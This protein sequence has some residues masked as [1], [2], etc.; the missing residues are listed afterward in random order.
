VAAVGAGTADAARAHGWPVALVPARHD[1]A[2]LAQAMA[3]AAPLRGARVLFPRAAAAR[4]TLPAALRAAGAEVTEVT[5]Y[6]T[7]AD[8]PGAAALR[9]HLL[10]RDVAVVT[11]A[12]GSAAHALVERV[13]VA[14]AARTRLVSIG[15]VTAAAVRSL[16]LDVVA[17]ASEASVAGIVA[18][19]VAASRDLVAARTADAGAPRPLTSPAPSL[20]DRA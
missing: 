4:D 11:L 9:A 19:V 16:G 2:A 12:S 8:A 10:R 6:R 20:E 14:L 13:G 3:A 7:V 15:A 5:L 1:A 17:E 18:A